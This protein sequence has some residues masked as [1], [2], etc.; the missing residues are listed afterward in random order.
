MISTIEREWCLL[1][2][3]DEQPIWNPGNALTGRIPAQDRD[4]IIERASEI[5]TTLEF[6]DFN[7]SCKIEMN[8]R[9]VCPK[10]YSINF[11]AWSCIKC[12]CPELLISIASVLQANNI[13][14]DSLSCLDEDDFSRLTKR[15]VEIATSA[16]IDG[17]DK[18]EALRLGLIEW[19]QQWSGSES[20]ELVELVRETRVM[21]GV[22]PYLEEG[23]DWAKQGF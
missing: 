22:F 9:W 3:E 10:E 17:N 2:V 7:D 5:C 6:S 20:D 1:L 14:D 8:Q 23:V 13:P 12:R 4:Y 21:R 15:L 18:R 19:L 11:L 16:I